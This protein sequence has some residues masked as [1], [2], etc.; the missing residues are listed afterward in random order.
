M[1]EHGHLADSTGW[2]QHNTRIGRQRVQFPWS[3]AEFVHT[4]AMKLPPDASRGSWI[5]CHRGPVGSSSLSIFN[6]RGTGMEKNLLFCFVLPY[7]IHTFDTLCSTMVSPAVSCLFP[8]Y[9]PHASRVW[10]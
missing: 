5:S 9:F 1:A 2:R 6:G 8:R 3:L 4:L 10:H 7:F